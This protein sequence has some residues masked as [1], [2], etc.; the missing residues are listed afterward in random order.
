VY[1]GENSDRS[2]SSPE[3][4]QI[5][6]GAHEAR[7]FGCSWAALMWC[8]NS[9]MLHFGQHMRKRCVA[10]GLCCRQ[11]GCR[12]SCCMACA[13]LAHCGTAALWWAAILEPV[14]AAHVV[15]LLSRCADSILQLLLW[16]AGGRCHY[17]GIGAFR[18]CADG[19]QA[20]VWA[21]GCGN[22]RL[23][24]S[25]MRRCNFSMTGVAPLGRACVRVEE[26]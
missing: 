22:Q 24:V 26:A 5:L 12:V 10:V 2:Y 4:K 23:R 13:A 9:A 15:A 8:R 21:G 6:V 11:L 19:W 14:L 20:A 1:N 18:R 7:R 3:L 17:R 25:A 16:T